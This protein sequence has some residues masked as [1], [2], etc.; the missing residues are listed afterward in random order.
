MILAQT[1]DVRTDVQAQGSVPGAPI[2]A[3]LLVAGG[4][5]VLL[6]R[7]RASG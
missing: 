5:V 6:V 1:G 4:G 2:A 3:L 7:R